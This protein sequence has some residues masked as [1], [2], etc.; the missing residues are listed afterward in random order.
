MGTTPHLAMLLQCSLAADQARERTALQMLALALWRRQAP[1]VR[2]HQGR[3]QSTGHTLLLTALAALLHT[4]Q[5]LQA[6]EAKVQVVVCLLLVG[7]LT[8]VELMHHRLQMRSTDAA[9]ERLAM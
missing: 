5:R 3:M 6:A 1:I 7:C 9:V 4:Q 8:G 2:C